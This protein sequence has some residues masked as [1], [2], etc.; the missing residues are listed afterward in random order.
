MALRL[1]DAPH[2][3][4]L[5]KRFADPNP[6][7]LI[8]LRIFE[9]FI[10]LAMM[11]DFTDAEGDRYFRIMNLTCRKLC[12]VRAHLDRYKAEQANAVAELHEAK[13]QRPDIKYI[14]DSQA[15]F[16][17]FDEFVVQVK[18]TLDHLAHI[19][20]PVFGENVWNMYTFGEKGEVLK[21]ALLRS[22]SQKKFG[23]GIAVIVKHLFD[24]AGQQSWL[25]ATI[26]ARHKITHYQRGGI[27]IETFAV[28][29]KP[30]GAVQLPEF[31]ENQTI[32]QFM[33][34]VWERLV[35]F[36]EDFLALFLALRLPP[37]TVFVRKNCD[38][39]TPNPVWI[40]MPT[41]VADEMAKGALRS[42]AYVTRGA[43]TP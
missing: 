10:T 41:Q 26:D 16:N 28:F 39:L 6:D 5:R 12:S 21:S 35:F 17:E 22:V 11:T 40:P 1:P 24:D 19:P 42:P 38:R 37:G 18:S 9:P 2:G 32:E 27:P 30:A 8:Y 43:S 4:T 13:A 33:E 29:L 23:G 34:I 25:E 7:R 20:V 15:M 36:V 31:A 14:D 3:A